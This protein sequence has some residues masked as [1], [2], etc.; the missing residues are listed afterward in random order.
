ME[1]QEKFLHH[2]W[3]QRHLVHEL[4]TVSG[5]TIRIV[6]QGQYNTNS[7]PDFKNV[8][9]SFG[10]E[11][12]QGDVEIHLKTY[13]WTAHRHSEDPIYNN[14][15]LH[16]VLEHKSSL[17]FTVREDAVSIDIL[18]LKHQIDADIAKLFTEFQ[19]NPQTRH[20]G[21]CDYFKLSSDEQLI[22]LL[23][24]NG[25]ERFQKKCN[26]YNAE[27]MFYGFDQLLY[28]GIMEAM[29]YD[30]NKFN[31]LA[32][33]QHFTWIKLQEWRKSGLNAITLAAIWLNYAGL[34]EKASAL[35]DKKYVA[36]LVRAFEYQAFTVENAALQWNLFRIRPANHPVKRIIQAAFIIDG[37]LNRGL[38]NSLLDVITCADV[39]NPKRLIAELKGIFQPDADIWECLEKPGLALITTISGNIILPILYLYAQKTN[40]AELLNKIC[41]LYDKFPAQSENFITNFMLGYLDEEKSVL[42]TGSYISQ[43]G[44]MNLYYRFC[45]YRL[46]ELCLK[47]KQRCMQNL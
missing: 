4:K 6:Y 39:T 19:A 18:E 32:L 29:G 11:T 28:N 7:G 40:D 16:V 30:K 43:Q 34:K 10:E 22:Q 24:T 33:A 8:I 42:A 13:D 9:L 44:L 14:T 31:T 46:C 36:E 23:K 25:W 47:E 12:V 37:L 45:K 41:C 3:D 2:I 38:L 20:I 1:L 15:I 5:K 21:L 27:L 17:T 35:L 26:R